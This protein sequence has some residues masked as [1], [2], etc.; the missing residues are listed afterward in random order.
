MLEQRNA[1]EQPHAQ[2]RSQTLSS[3]TTALR[4]LQCFSMEEP[5]LGVTEIAQRLGVG[6]STVHRILVTLEE[7]GFVR[8]DETT[9]RYRLGLSVLTL[10]GI[11]MSNLE[12]Y[13]EGQHLLESFVNR[14]DETVHLAVLEGFNTVYVSKI[15]S[16]HPVPMLTHLGRKNPLHCTSSGKAILAFQDEEMIDEVIRRGLTRY[17]RTTITDPVR[18]HQHLEEIRQKGFATSEGELRDGV[19][20]VAVPVRDYTRRVIG[21]VTVVGPTYRFTP[22]KVDAFARQLIDVGAEISKRLG[23]Y[24]RR[25]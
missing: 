9:R 16:K 11:L 18:L 5:E 10:G 20:S 8:K 19:S 12:I 24:V 1:R 17:T 7:S 13:R 21:A 15:E 4:V 14:F 2:G 6:K 23:Y 25:R 22:N 3:L